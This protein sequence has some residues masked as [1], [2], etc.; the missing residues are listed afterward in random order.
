MGSLALF[1]KVYTFAFR[2]TGQ[3]ASASELALAYLTMTSKECGWQPQKPV[4]PEMPVA[5]IK[6]VYR[7]FVNQI[8][9]RGRSP[10]P[11]P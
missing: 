5:S 7:L 10:A 6:E 3:A 11:L 1:N 9:T 4:P 8:W 2:L